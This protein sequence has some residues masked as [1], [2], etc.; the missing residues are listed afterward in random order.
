VY[1]PALIQSDPQ[2]RARWDAQALRWRILYGYW[3][4]DLRR[5]IERE[6]GL[7]RADG[8]GEPDIGSNLLAAAAAAVS[9]LYDRGATVHHDSVRAAQRMQR[10]LDAAGWQNVMQRLQRDTIA[11]R[12]MAVRVD[13]L[14]GEAGPR[15]VLH[16]VPPHA[17][18]IVTAEGDPD[19]LLEVRWWRLREREGRQI[20]TCDVT[21]TRPGRERY[22][23]EDE[24][25][26]DVSPLFLVDADGRPAPEGGYRGDAYPYRYAGAAYQPW[27][28]Y[29]AA[30]TGQLWDYGSNVEIVSAT[31]K[32][33]RLWTYWGHIVQTASW[34]QRYLIGGEVGG[35]ATYGD[36]PSARRQVVADPAV[37]LKIVRDEMS[38]GEPK[39]H[40][41]ATNADPHSLQ[42]SIA[43]YERAKVAL[44]GLNPADVSRVSGDPRSGYALAITRDGQREAQR[45]YAPVFRRGDEGLCGIVARL[46]GDL[47]ATGWR[48]SYD[49][50]PLTTSELLEVQRYVSAEIQAG[51]MTQLQAYMLLHPDLSVDD[52]DAQL[53]AI[54][55]TTATVAP[56]L[57]QITASVVR[58]I[59][60]DVAAGT[61]PRASGVALL[62]LVAP[63]TTQQA[64][65]LLP[66]E[67]EPAPAP[68][69]PMMTPEEDTDDDDDE[70]DDDPAA[71]GDDP[72][73]DDADAGIDDD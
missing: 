51:R 5:S 25:G 26:Q 14:P 55:A 72:A 20:W 47:P 57:D 3:I 67:P 31:L 48:V 22:A 65:T 50:I 64:D 66:L 13:L 59:V 45:R 10:V 71:A 61:M 46:L 9:T 35:Q 32:I 36:G 18:E 16:P 28:V 44:A 23:I 43:A 40:Q 54:R 30:M 15:V 49:P 8:W 21:D 58:S 38:D 68:A 37:L 41:D 1:V 70:R 53:E 17:L 52:A 69:A 24:H 42:E 63:L 2:T 33:G 12:E 19:T 62:P 4:D 29:H 11:I 39:I 60:A 7:E 27:Q 6:V 34:P 56:V 73:D